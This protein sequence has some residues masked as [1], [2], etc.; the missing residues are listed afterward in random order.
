MPSYRNQWIDLICSANQLNDCYMMTTF[1][2]FNKSTHLMSL[3]S[4]YTPW[5]NKL[6]R[7]FLIFSEG[8]ER[9]VSWTGLIILTRLLSIFKNLYKF[10]F[11][12]HLALKIR[13]CVT[14]FLGSFF[15]N[16]LFSNAKMEIHKRP[17]YWKSRSNLSIFTENKIYWI[18]KITDGRIIWYKSNTES[19]Y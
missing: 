10:K 17:P 15:H 8:I 9:P 11:F 18:N 12:S 3:I 6:T 4:F 5:R 1:N 19:L 7:G 13:T 16:C 14:F 2:K